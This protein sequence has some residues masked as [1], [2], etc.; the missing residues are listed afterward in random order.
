[1]WKSRDETRI[2]NRNRFKLGLFGANCSGGLSLTKAPERWRATWQDNVTAAR[3]ADEAGLEFLL[4][5]GRWVGYKGE[6]DTQGTTFETQTW[7]CGILASTKHINAFGTLHVAFV[8]P[9]FAAK[10][11]V[12]ADHI[13]GGRFGLNIV[14]G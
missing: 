5:I 8:S 4:P 12:T 14:S 13:G 9:V 6:T 7:A 11:M 1:M 3:L 10:Q 2:Y